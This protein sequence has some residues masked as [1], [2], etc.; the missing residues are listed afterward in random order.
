MGYKDL[1]KNVAGLDIDGKLVEKFLNCAMSSTIQ[2]EFYTSKDEQTKKTLKIH[3]E[4]FDDSREFYSVSLLLNINDIHKMIVIKTLMEND[5]DNDKKDQEN[6]IVLD[7]L[8]KM[9]TNRAFKALYVLALNK[10]NNARVR[11]LIRQ[12]IR[13]RENLVFEAVKYKKFLKAIARHAHVDFEKIAKNKDVERFIYD[14]EPDKIKEKLFKDYLKAK[15][16]KASVF[17]LPYSVAEGFK[18]LHKID[19]A[20]FMEKIKGKMSQAEKRRSQGRAEKSDVK[21]E[22]NLSRETPVNIQKYLRSD[23]GTKDK[24]KGLKEFEKSCKKE[25]E[26][27][28]EYFKFDNVKIIVDNSESMSGSKE[29]KDH[30]IAVAEAVAGVLKY[31]SDDT[32]IVGTPNDHNFLTKPMGRTCIG[33]ALLKALKDLDLE[34]DNIVL[35]ISDGYEN[36]PD[37]A[38]HMVTYAFKKKLDKKEKTIIIHL[39]PVFAPE[40]EDIKKLSDLIDTYGVRDQKQLFLILMLAIIKNK[41]DKKIKEIINGMKKKVV[42]RKKK[43]RGNKK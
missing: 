10:V 28:F 6:N 11:W 16:D 27:L 29:K 32:E 21:I 15:T 40:A 14:K 7:S 22:F 23:A 38:T 26:K 18:N 5:I 17:K 20:E 37:G 43:K 33:E 3:K 42:I 19:D 39:N 2:E 12:F 9:P 8:K 41:K 31:L 34:K 30:P 1:L 36:S 4:M 24:N 13:E 25:A 35:I